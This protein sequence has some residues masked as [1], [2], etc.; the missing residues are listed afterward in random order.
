M[1]DTSTARFGAR[2]QS[3]GSNTNTWGDTKLN[4]NFDLFD[5]GTKGYQSVTLTGD[6]TFT[7]TNYSASNQGQVQVLRFGGSLSSAV[8]VTVPSVEWVWDVINASGAQV[9]LKTAAGAGV[10]IPNGRTVRLYCDGTDVYSVV[11]NYLPIDITETNNRDLIDYAA[12]NTAIANASTITSPGQVKVSTNDT[13][14]NFLSAKFTT[15]ISG[16]LNLQLA[17]INPGANEQIRINA[18]VATSALADGGEQTAGFTAASNTKYRVRWSTPQTIT[19]PASP[20]AGD[21]IQIA[22]ATTAST[23]LARNGNLIN[24]AAADFVVGAGYFTETYTYNATAGWC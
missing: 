14:A 15:N 10:A 1:A 8:S 24:N 23:T 7:W 16:A 6:V 11:P 13:T 21:Q 4:D 9:T 19:L 18:S 22:Y 12:L 2:K 20:S 17:T 3:L 5:R